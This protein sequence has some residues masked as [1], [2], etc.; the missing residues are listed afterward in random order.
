MGMASWMSHKEKRATKIKKLMEKEQ[1]EPL[2]IRA[3]SSDPMALISTHQQRTANLE[4][5]PKYISDQAQ[6]IA[7]FQDMERTLGDDFIHACIRRWNTLPHKLQIREYHSPA[8]MK[9]ELRRVS[10]YKHSM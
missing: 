4:S 3:K 5:S 2:M 10:L 6:A 9:E 8:R 1:N 7:H